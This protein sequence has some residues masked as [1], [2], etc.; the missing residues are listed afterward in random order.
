MTLMYSALTRFSA[1]QTDLLAAAA[2]VTVLL[3]GQKND[4]AGDRW[5][6]AAS[7]TPQDNATRRCGRRRLI[8]APHILVFLYAP[9]RG[10][11]RLL[12]DKLV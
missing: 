12:F 5:L 10:R 1:W 8:L 9:T 4:S 6:H 7:A 3:K 2:V 11:T